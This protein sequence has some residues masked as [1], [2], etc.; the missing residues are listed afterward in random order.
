M[1]INQYISRSTGYSRRK[2]EELVLA[3]RIKVAFFV[4]PEKSGIQPTDEIVTNLATEVNPL[5][6]VFLDDK[7]IQPQKFV[8]YALNKPVGYTTT[9][10]DPHAEKLI[11]ELVPKDPPVFPVGRLDKDT[12]GLIFLTND[13]DFAQ[14]M[15]HPKYEKEKEYIV[16]TDKE[17]SDKS[18]NK[19]RNGIEL[20][21]GITAPAKVKIISAKKYSITIHE[22]KNR[23]VRRMIEAVGAKVITLKRIRIGDFELENLEEGKYKKFA[24]SNF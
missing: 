15:T 22:G 12:S 4:I 19:L 5:D 14:K 10:S 24:T 2:A 16:E 8:Y 3:G 13:G 20:D 23:Q 11:T 6:K 17:L 9:T 7:L 18:L 21:D 1:R